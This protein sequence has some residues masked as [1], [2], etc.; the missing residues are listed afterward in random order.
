LDNETA[1]KNSTSPGKFLLE[2]SFAAITKLPVR[3]R[4]EVSDLRLG[5]KSRIF[6]EK[7]GDAYF[8]QKVQ[9]LEC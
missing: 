2:T 8:K 6:A 7:I 5:K 9:I 3:N 4:Q 1:V